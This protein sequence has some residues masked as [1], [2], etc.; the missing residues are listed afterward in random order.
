MGRHNI[1]KIDDNMSNKLTCI[2]IF[3]RPYMFNTHTKMLWTVNTAYEYQT[4]YDM[5]T[6]WPNIYPS[7]MIFLCEAN[8]FKPDYPNHMFLLPEVHTPP[9]YFPNSHDP[10]ELDPDVLRLQH[11]PDVGPSKPWYQQ[12]YGDLDSDDEDYNNLS[13]SQNSM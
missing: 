13:P 8:N 2:F 5:D 4:V 7:L 1:W 11:Q 12:F 6:Q 9:P 3:H 10:M